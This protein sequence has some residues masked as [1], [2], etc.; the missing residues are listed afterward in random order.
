MASNFRGKITIFTDFFGKITIFPI[1]MTAIMEILQISKIASVTF[2][3]SYFYT[4]WPKISFLAQFL[5]ETPSWC[6][7]YDLAEKRIWSSYPM[8]KPLYFQNFKIEFLENE[9]IF[10]N[11]V[12]SVWFISISSL[13]W[14]KHAQIHLSP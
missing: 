13:I 11:S 8:S 1:K 10:F 14:T 5:E 7:L 12:K 2:F 3:A 9:K 4:F 6:I